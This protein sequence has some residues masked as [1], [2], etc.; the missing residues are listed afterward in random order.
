MKT[1]ATICLV[2]I[3]LAA[4][5]LFAAER[6]VV[7]D[8]AAERAAAITNFMARAQASRTR[9]PKESLTISTNTVHLRHDTY[10]GTQGTGMV[11]VAWTVAGGRTNRTEMLRSNPLK[12]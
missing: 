9:L 3:W 8:F 5:G 2:A 4:V 6:I 12:P 7:R 10:S 11:I 1:L